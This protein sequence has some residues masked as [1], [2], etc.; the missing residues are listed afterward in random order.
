[1]MGVE[2]FN[3]LRYIRLITAV[4][5]GVEFLKTEVKSV[6]T[7]NIINYR[8]FS[9]T[10]LQKKLSCT[11]EQKISEAAE[12]HSDYWNRKRLLRE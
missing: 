1:M 11:R 7:N 9:T 4:D 8:I 5:N 3:K 6:I 2:N 12:K 10:Q